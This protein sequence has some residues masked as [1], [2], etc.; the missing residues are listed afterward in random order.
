MQL[1]YVRPKGK[2]SLQNVVSMVT[3]NACTHGPSYI[4][5]SKRRS[6]RLRFNEHLRD[7][8]KERHFP[9]AFQDMSPNLPNRRKHSDHFYRYYKDAKT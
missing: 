7:A 4:G 8:K 5:E 1:L 6:V 9:R 2:M 3:C